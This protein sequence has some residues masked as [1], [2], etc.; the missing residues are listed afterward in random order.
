MVKW[1]NAQLRASLAPAL[2]IVDSGSCVIAREN[3]TEGSSHLFRNFSVSRDWEKQCQPGRSITAHFGLAHPRRFHHR[4]C[5]TAA[6]EKPY[7]GGSERNR[8][9]ARARCFWL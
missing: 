5:P 8:Y 1:P 4:D 2:P 6:R 9:H 3:R 7:P